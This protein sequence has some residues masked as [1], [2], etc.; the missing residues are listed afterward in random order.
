M[1]QGRIM[2]MDTN[3]PVDRRNIRSTSTRLGLRDSVLFPALDSARRER[4]VPTNYYV[5]VHG[6]TLTI[7]VDDFFVPD[8]ERTRLAAKYRDY[9]GRWLSSPARRWF[10]RDGF[11]LADFRCYVPL[12]VLR[13]DAEEWIAELNQVGPLTFKPDW[14]FRRAS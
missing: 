9:L 1:P 4:R 11:G 3:A 7:I 6:R 14:R 13:E 5:R 8:E 12:L 10:P 2:S